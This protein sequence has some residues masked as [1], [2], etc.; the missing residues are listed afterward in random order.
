[1]GFRIKDLQAAALPLSGTEIIELEQGENSRQVR[2]MD[3]LPGFDGDT[4]AAQ[5]SAPEGATL[6]S[7]GGETV[8]VALDRAGES[9]EFAHGNIKVNQSDYATI[10]PN[11][12]PNMA[13]IVRTGF[14]SAGVH[15]AGSIATMVGPVVGN[16]SF[17]H[18]LVELTIKTT[19]R[20]KVNV[21]MGSAPLI[22]DH[23]D[24]YPFVVGGVATTGIENNRAIDDVTY[25]FMYETSGTTFSQ[26]TVKTDASWAGQITSVKLFAVSPMKFAVGG[27]ATG[28]G[29]HNPMGIKVGGYARNDI[30]LGDKFSLAAFYPDDGLPK[31]PAHNLAIGAKALASCRDGDQNTAVGTYTLQF[32]QTSNCTAVG[33]SALKL[34]TK[35]RENTAIGY[36]SL[37]SNTVGS[38]NVASG[39]WALGLLV[40][41]DFN[42]ATGWYAGRNL[43]SGSS[44]TYNGARAGFSNAGGVG[45][46]YN[47]AHAGYGNGALFGP[48]DYVTCSGS[49]SWA[50]GVGA[51]TH[52]VQARVGTLTTASPEG[53][54]LGHLS[55][56]T[57]DYAPTAVG[58]AAT[59]SGTRSTACGEEAKA[60]G[61]QATATGALAQANGDYTVAN[62][63]QAGVGNT[64]TRNTFI[65]PSAGA[66]VNAFSNVSAIGSFSQIT[67][68]NQIQLGDSA[69][70]TFAFGAVQNRSDGRDKADIRNT[71]L[72]LDFIL[73]LRPVDF[74]W[75]YRDDYREIDKKGRVTELVK[76]GSKKRERFHHG[77]IAQEVAQTASDLGVEFG[78][79]QDHSVN[80]GK[81]IQ[82]LGHAEL[83]APIVRAIQEIA[84][85][86]RALREEINLL[87]GI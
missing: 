12:G 78:G 69:T 48:F 67:G 30:A 54:A 81:D 61:A 36:K 46:T 21:L 80:G 76:D 70:T 63:A 85:E 64:G 16:N 68:N 1:M 66:G 51:T 33:Y 44:N 7:N 77:F 25:T 2:V 45:C 53:T 22:G 17:G 6:V 31:T 56:A 28:N 39:F 5:L 15:G 52:G 20:G 57:G 41:G 40:D 14:D 72:G 82:S 65:G 71:V 38:R 29:V 23:P 4:L 8:A 58:Y 27:A 26:M 55:S 79:H 59:A 87:K 83:F 18:Y 73:A 35:G 10:G 75:D 42:T 47:G 32:H 86:N 34:N 19:A 49:E 84:A 9:N 62:G 74:R 37:T 24:G 13:T 3:L 11:I 50:F 60:I 43:L